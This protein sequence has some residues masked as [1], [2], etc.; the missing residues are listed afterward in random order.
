MGNAFGIDRRRSTGS[1][2]LVKFKD[3]VTP[4]RWRLQHG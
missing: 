1:L 4:P 3:L 2:H